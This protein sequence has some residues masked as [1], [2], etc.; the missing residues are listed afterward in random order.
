MSTDDEK[1]IDSP[2]RIRQENWR[3]ALAKTK[4]IAEFQGKLSGIIPPASEEEARE[5]ERL[6]KLGETEGERD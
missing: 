1:P 4:E 5:I 3:R 2:L 6:R